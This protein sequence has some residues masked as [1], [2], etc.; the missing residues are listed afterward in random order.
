MGTAPLCFEIRC[1]LLENFR[2]TGTPLW[3]R[4]RTSAGLWHRGAPFIVFVLCSQCPVLSRGDRCF[5]GDLVGT[6][7]MC[8]QPLEFPVDLLAEFMLASVALASHRWRNRVGLP[9]Q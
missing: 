5:D 9:V 3:P 8:C 7:M 6:S 1:S 4:Y 2:C